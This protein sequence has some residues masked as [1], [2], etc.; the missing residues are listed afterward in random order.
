[1]ERVSK[2]WQILDQILDGSP[3][4][5][6]RW[7]NNS[8]LKV[9]YQSLFP[10]CTFLLHWLGCSALLFIHSCSR[11]GVHAVH[12]WEKMRWRVGERTKTFNPIWICVT[13][14]SKMGGQWCW[15]ARGPL[16]ENVSHSY[17]LV[18]SKLNLLGGSMS[19]LLLHP[20]GSC[21]SLA[22]LSLPLLFSS[23]THPVE[24]DVIITSHAHEWCVLEWVCC[25][26]HT[27][28]TEGR[29]GRKFKPFILWPRSVPPTKKGRK[30]NI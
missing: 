4:Q 16:E 21:S 27:G 11:G 5:L 18:S 20:S 3:A 7:E 14:R 1:M 2:S 29:G 6:N 12:W 10:W 13:C 23:H 24:Y 17:V 22:S 26:H 19:F 8:C 28:S 15:G 30:K 25:W 9:K